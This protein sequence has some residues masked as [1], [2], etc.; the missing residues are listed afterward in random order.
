MNLED[1][2]VF[3]GAELESATEELQVE[4]EELAGCYPVY[5]HEAGELIR[6]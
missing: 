1:I 5:V 2:I 6:Q 4:V 3:D